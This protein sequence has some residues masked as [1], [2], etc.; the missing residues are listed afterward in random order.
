MARAIGLRP[1]ARGE[2]VLGLLPVCTWRAE[3]RGDSGNG[4]REE[5]SSHVQAAA[6][7]GAL[8]DKKTGAARTAGAVPT[9]CVFNGI[10][11]E[12]ERARGRRAAR[13]GF[14]CGSGR[15]EGLKI[16]ASAFLCPRMGD[17][18]W[19]RKMRTRIRWKES[20]GKTDDEGRLRMCGHRGED[21]GRLS[22]SVARPAADERTE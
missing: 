13:L 10:D 19:C 22:D 21:E 15:I 12:D 4:H 7:A 11:H 3:L 14:E 17:N 2:H 1:G 8:S 5:P 18:G 6:W 9:A 16:S 20:Q